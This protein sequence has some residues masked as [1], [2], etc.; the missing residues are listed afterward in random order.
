MIEEPN[1]QNPEVEFERQDLGAKPILGF[2]LG[3]CVAG[4]I[5]YFV[6]WGLYRFLDA[7]ERA[8]QPQQ[9]P[10]VKAGTE[11]S[12]APEVDLE[13]FPKPRL[14][15]YERVDFNR[16]RR[17]EEQRLNSYG[18]V[19]EQAG[20][21]RI[22]I[23]RAMELTAQRGLPVTPRSGEV[24]AS[25]VNTVRRAAGSSDRSQLQKLQKGKEE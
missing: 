19:D 6:I 17:D 21:L 22:P 14:E 3:L 20:V 25:V 1:I 13:Q 18:W 23:D 9:N 2:L 4:V 8:H 24:P 10:L 15:K 7:R 11:T 12:F 16:F 5:L